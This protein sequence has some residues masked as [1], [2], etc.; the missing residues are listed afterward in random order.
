MLLKMYFEVAQTDHHIINRNCW[1]DGMPHL[2]FTKTVSNVHATIED[3]FVRFACN[4]CYWCML[5]CMAYCANALPL[6]TGSSTFSLLLFRHFNSLQTVIG[7][8]GFN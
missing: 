5:V 4:G 8:I 3:V 1:I 2:H 7:M 6:T